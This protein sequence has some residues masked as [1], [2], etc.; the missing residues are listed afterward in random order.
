MK[1]P[2]DALIEQAENAGVGAGPVPENDYGEPLDADQLAMDAA[3]RYE[4]RWRDRGCD[5]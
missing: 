3:D 1:S 4:W 2:D 5:D